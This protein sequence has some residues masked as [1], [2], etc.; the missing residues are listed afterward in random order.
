MWKEERMRKPTDTSIRIPSL[1]SQ[2]QDFKMQPPKY[3]TLGCCV[4]ILIIGALFN[5]PNSPPPISVCFHY[6]DSPTFYKRLYIIL[7][8]VTFSVLCFSWWKMSHLGPALKGFKPGTN[9]TVTDTW[10]EGGVN[11]EASMPKLTTHIF[12]IKNKQKWMDLHN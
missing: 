12:I 4:H 1:R 5:K 2:V 6:V 11:T 10:W 8:Y 9:I 7:V 3:E